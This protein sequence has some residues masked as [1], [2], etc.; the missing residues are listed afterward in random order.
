[1]E[2]GCRPQSGSCPADGLCGAGIDLWTGNARR[3][4]QDL[5]FCLRAVQRPHARPSVYGGKVPQIRDL[6]SKLANDDRAR[7]GAM[8]TV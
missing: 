8:F 2:N 3:A 7:D 1:M 4:G 6:T 5:A